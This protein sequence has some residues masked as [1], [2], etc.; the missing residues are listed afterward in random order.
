MVTIN[1]ANNKTAA[2]GTILQGQG[3]ATAS[4]YSTATYP[5]VSGTSGKILISDGTNIVSSTPTYPNAS[6]T[7]GKVIISDGT[8]YIA[9]T[10]TYPNTSGGAG[11]ILRSDGTNNVYTTATY[12]ATTTINRILFSSAANVIGEITT[13]NNGVVVTGT[14]GIPSVLAAGTAGAILRSGAPAAWSTTTYPAT[15]AINTIL[16]ASAANVMSALATA[17]NGTLVTS[18]TGVPS[19]LVGPGATGR[20]FQSTAAAAPAWST[21]TYPATTTSQQILYSTAANVVGELTTANSRFPATNAAGTLAMR[22]L[23]VVIQTFVANGTYTPTSGMLFCVV[24]MCGPG[25]G[26]GGVAACTAA[27]SAQ[28]GAGGAGEYARGVFSAATIGASQAVTCPAGGA[29]GAAGANNGTA[30][31]NTT[32]L[33]ALI[34]A[35]GGAGGAGAAAV[36][37]GQTTA[38]GAGGTGGAGGSFRSPGQPG[39]NS[40]GSFATFSMM[41][42]GGSSPFGGGALGLVAGAAGTAAGG[43]GAGGGG[44]LGFNS[45]ARAGG[46]GSS[47]IIVITE[48]VIA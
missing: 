23:S 3:I 24:E 12:P 42:N 4:E 38:G 48:Y 22:A 37:A 25:G 17:N 11:V 40:T 16:Y 43:N 26:G 36:A 27:Q 20:M 47:A 33:G 30:G 6:V 2:L 13:A 39:G 7:A 28:A 35:F 14:T 8:N 21:A 32:A 10:P 19:I 15:N 46:N 1:S 9:S 34:T 5:S 29:G 31:A 18:A 45:V 44:A 41:G